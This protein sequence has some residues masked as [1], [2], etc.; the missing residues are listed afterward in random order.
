M[1]CR[2]CGANLIEG[3]RFCSNCC[4]P[5]DYDYQTSGMGGGVYAPRKMGYSY[6]NGSTPL[7]NYKGGAVKP[8]KKHTVRNIFLG[9]IILFALTI[10]SHIWSEIP[11]GNP[12]YCGGTLKEGTWDYNE[13]NFTYTVKNGYEQE[14][15]MGHGETIK[16]YYLPSGD[17]RLETVETPLSF[18]IY[19][20]VPPTDKRYY[21]W[22]TGS[23]RYNLGE[24]VSDMKMFPEVVGNEQN[25]VI[26]SPSE[27]GDGTYPKYNYSMGNNGYYGGYVTLEKYN[28]VVVTKG[29][30]KLIPY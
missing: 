4:A 26:W 17:Y 25:F 6:P 23:I 16:G 7:P 1:F 5:V 13:S 24:G 9:L 12:I 30:M 2:H 20:F 27:L 29:K 21:T 14:I 8:K 10:F 15:S 11:S 3:S 19:Q 22:C 28:L 18:V